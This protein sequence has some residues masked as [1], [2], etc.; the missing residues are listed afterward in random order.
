MGL[1]S[2]RIMLSVPF[3]L[4]AVALP[5]LL[6]PFLARVLQTKGLGAFATGQS[7][8]IVVGSVVDFGA[9]I[10]ATRLVVAEREDSSGLSRI[11]SDTLAAK[12]I[13]AVVA[14]SVS[15]IAAFFVPVFADDAPLFASSLLFGLAQGFNLFWFFGG[16][17]RQLTG[18]ALDFGARLV[19]TG[20]ILMWV[21]QPEDAWKAMACF[22]IAQLAFVLIGFQL[23]RKWTTLGRLSVRAGIGMLAKGRHIF[24]IHVLGTI[25]TGS[26][27][28]LLGFVASPE[29][30][31]YFN[32][33]ERLIRASA[34]PLMPLRQIIFPSV[35]ARLKVSRKEGARLIVKIFIL[36][37]LV[38][39]IASLIFYFGSSLVVKIALGEAMSQAATYLKVMA[40]V[41]LFLGAAE[42]IGVFWLFAMGREGTVTWV[43]A[44]VTTLHI[45][46][47][48]VFGR[49]FGGIGGAAVV[50]ASQILM[51]VLTTMQTYGRR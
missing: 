30:V 46:M 3:Q 13:A 39:A 37:C 25:Y 40:V 1:G 16:L 32:G 4:A 29:A 41:P 38:M 50:A 35:V 12:I 51:V 8:A 17:Q 10:S 28:L 20:A 7:L 6:L 49:Q 34:M 24:A 18:S 45:G 9:H 2:S 15:L 19:A 43:L 48:L 14:A 23:S 33:A 5:I 47:M 31:G 44:V 11:F 22:A 21:R 27:A 26:N 42:V 36:Y